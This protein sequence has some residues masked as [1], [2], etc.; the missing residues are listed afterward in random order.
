MVIKKNNY[1]IPTFGALLIL[2]RDEDLLKNQIKV[3]LRK[4]DEKK[5]L[6]CKFKITLFS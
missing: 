6:Y 1:F 3:Y 5:T 4:F 2:Q